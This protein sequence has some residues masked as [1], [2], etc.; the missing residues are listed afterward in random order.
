MYATWLFASGIGP[1]L[2][3]RS[4][5]DE[6]D[7]EVLV[8]KGR[9]G[10]AESRIVT[11][12]DENGEKHS[13][14]RRICYS[15]DDDWDIPSKYRFYQSYRL[16]DSYILPSPA[17]NKNEQEASY[18]YNPRG[19][20][21]IKQQLLANRG[22][23]ICINAESSKENAE[24]E[25]PADHPEEEEEDDLL[26]DPRPDEW[27]EFI[28]NRKESYV[29]TGG[30]WL[31]LTSSEAKDFIL[32]PAKKEADF[33]DMYETTPPDIYD[34][35]PIKAYLVEADQPAYPIPAEDITVG[36]IPGSNSKQVIFKLGGRVEE[37]DTNPVFAW[38]SS[39]TGIFT[40]QTVDPEEGGNG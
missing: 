11:W 22:V 32:G 28:V 21:A 17:Q 34:N 15:K 20:E 16:K 10:E 25:E 31:D 4:G 27:D 29:L 6:G 18:T 3:D 19:T 36:S 39:D 12:Y 9:N 23:S 37:W 5:L 8:Y 30:K 24:L 26:S 40:V 33:S 1:N 13:G 35:L 38:A 7:E 2:E 14:V